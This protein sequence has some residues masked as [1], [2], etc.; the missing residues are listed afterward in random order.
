MKG[1]TTLSK[2][3]IRKIGIA[4]SAFGIV[5]AIAEKKSGF[6]LIHQLTVQ[7]HYF[8]CLYIILLG[9]LLIATGKV[10]HEDDRARQMR[11]KAL[12]ISYTTLIVI[13]INCA[14]IATL[15]GKL[16][17]GPGELFLMAA[18]SLIQF[19]LSYNLGLHFD[20]IADYR[21]KSFRKNSKLMASNKWR[22]LVWIFICTFLS[23][24]LI[25]YL[26][27]L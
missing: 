26:S 6:I 10:K 16:T 3:P 23:S 24:F 9:L 14:L 13:V 27:K 7:Q 19:L 21:D 17:F 5:A 22:I 2:F 25:T 15:Y 1:I 12:Q 4:I 20:F 11:A 8:I 18:I